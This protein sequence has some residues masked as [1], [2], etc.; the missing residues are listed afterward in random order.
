MEINYLGKTIET[1]EKMKDAET[2][3][4]TEK[5]LSQCD[6]LLQQINELYNENNIKTLEIYNLKKELQILQQ[7]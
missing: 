6:M 1:L 2:K 5:L 7:K 4:I 3:C